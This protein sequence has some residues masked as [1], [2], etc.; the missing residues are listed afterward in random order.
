MDE[1]LSDLLREMEI[2]QS[3]ITE[4]IH[5]VY[6]GGGTPS[7]I[8]PKEISSFLGRLSNMISLSDAKEI[9]IE[10]NPG[11]VSKDW[12]KAISES[13]VNRLSFGMQASQKSVL[14]TL[15]RIHAPEDVKRSID[16]ARNT[17]FRNIN[18]DLMFGIPGQTIGDWNQTLSFALS[19][20]PEHISAYGLI[21][22]EG[23][24]LYSRLKS[25]ELTLPDP[26]AER[27]MYDIA[28]SRLH[29]AGLEQ[30]ELSNFARS[31]YECVHN[32]GYWDQIPYIGIG[33]SA[34]SMRKV[35]SSPD[36]V[37]SI[38]RTN[39][40]S[41]SDYRNM[42]DHPERYPAETESI[43]P[44]EARFETVMLALRMNRGISRKR[45]AELHGNPPEYY[46]G[47][48]LHR[49]KNQNLLC[50]QDDCWRLTRRGM[51]IQN[52]IL[53]QFMQ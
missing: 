27:E 3:E 11:T 16:D 23:T 7:L 15:E 40:R 22:E 48:I 12:L 20:N 30:Y 34:A 33:L 49:L 10:A 2:R 38:R 42:L 39:P 1:Y 52:S 32:I 5:T 43:T 29:E 26:D 53:L 28:I 45:F 36:R 21:P 50:F 13:G 14:K 6:I 44:S 9:S 41:F 31:G 17:G 18:L 35:T 25:G 19:M 51:D 4:P 46:Y 24:P 8:P 37:F 47:E